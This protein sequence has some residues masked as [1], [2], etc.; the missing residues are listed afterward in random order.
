MPSISPGSSPH[1]TANRD[2]ARTMRRMASVSHSQSAS[3][4]SN[5]RRS[6]LTVSSRSLSVISLARIKTSAR[7][8]LMQAAINNS[9]KPRMPNAA[10]VV[11]A[12]SS[13]M[14][15]D[16]PRYPRKINVASVNGAIA[17]AAAVI[18]MVSVM[19]SP[20][21]APDGTCVQKR[22]GTHDQPRPSASPSHPVR[23]KSWRLAWL[24]PL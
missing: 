3:V 10:E 9:V 5:S 2:D 19:P 15:I 14:T 16:A 6:R 7:A 18:R 24:S 1:A 12:I 22:I 4:S 21:V 11:P 17:N 13:W 20:A 23:R 8:R